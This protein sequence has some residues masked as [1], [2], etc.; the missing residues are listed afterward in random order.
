[1]SDIT[2]MSC[3]TQS[4]T[5]FSMQKTNILI[6]GSGGF[7]GKNLT[8]QLKNKYRI[9]SPSS[10]E[11][12]LFDKRSV[13]VF[14]EKNK[15]DTI[16]HAALY[17]GPDKKQ[18]S[19]DMLR[20]NL[21]MFFNLIDNK[22]KYKKMIFF[23][24]GAE[25]NKSKPI[26]DV[27]EKDF[28]KSIPED[29]YGTLKYTISRYI[30]NAENIVDLRLF[31]VYGKHEDYRRRFISYAICKSIFNLPIEIKQNVYFDYLYIDDLIRIVD[32]FI[33]NKVDQKFYNVG[34]GKKID[35]LTLAKLIREITNIKNEITVIKK[36]LANEYTCNNRKL[37]KEIKPL[38]L[39]SFEDSI[40]SMTKW[41]QSKKKEININD[42]I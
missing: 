41:Y 40:K 9:L 28:G 16:I 27:S 21:V 26:I 38:N 23:G 17:V 15:I 34:R 39:T 18:F 35:L 11:L 8:E 20:K 36:G 10:K 14:F 2:L 6:T 22:K 37:S 30:E 13:H 1:M 42:L 4:A 24:S 19:Q 31:G 25:Y 32:Y 3:L 5:Q 12:N 29:D 7:I 33:C